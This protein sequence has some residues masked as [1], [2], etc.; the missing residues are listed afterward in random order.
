MLQLRPAG[1]AS[2][3][4]MP[5]ASPSPWFVSVTVKPISSPAETL[6]ASAVLSTSMSAQLTSTEAEDSSNPS[7]VVVTDAVLSTSPQFALVVV[8]ITCTVELAPPA[9]V[10]CLKT[11]LPPA[12]SQSALAGSIVQVR[13]AGRTSVKSRPLASPSPWLVSV[14]VKPICSPAETL[15][16][17]AVLSTSM[18]AQ[19]TSTEAEDSS[20][21]SLEVLTD[22]VLS[23]SPQFSFDVVAITC[24]VELELPAR[25]DGLN[26]RL[27]AVICQSLLAGSIDHV[28]PPGRTS[29]NWMPLA[30]PSPVL[31]SVTVNPICSPAE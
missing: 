18:S 30:S 26:T 21:P 13:P 7:L 1:S 4:S 16:A 6:A 22:A 5:L 14:T 19:S 9:S 15:A 17:S 12:I 2:V 3:N 27:P 31:E 23:T 8:A 10:S 28:R 24:T 11:S 29:V 20:D 25:V